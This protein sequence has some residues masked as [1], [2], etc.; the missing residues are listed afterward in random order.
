MHMT[1]NKKNMSW[2][3]THLDKAQ[4]WKQHAET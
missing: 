3:L 4:I 2:Y 1:E